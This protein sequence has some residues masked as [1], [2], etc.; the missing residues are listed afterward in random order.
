[1]C[2]HAKVAAIFIFILFFY[3]NL[4]LFINIF[5]YCTLMETYVH[6][7]T[8]VLWLLQF[9]QLLKYMLCCA[10]CNQSECLDFNLFVT[11]TD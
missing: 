2:S 10:K 9:V 5:W 8:Y 1:M 11:E 6:M 4:C 7:C 3:I